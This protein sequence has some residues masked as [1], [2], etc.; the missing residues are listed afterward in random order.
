MKGQLLS[1]PQGLRGFTDVTRQSSIDTEGYGS[2]YQVEKPGRTLKQLEVFLGRLEG[3]REGN[4]K[5]AI[6]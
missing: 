3:V 4:K 1:P 6:N 5:K 2:W